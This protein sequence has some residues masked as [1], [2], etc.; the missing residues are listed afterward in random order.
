MATAPITLSLNTSNGFSPNSVPTLSLWLDAADATT[1]SFSSGINVSQWNDKS[2]SANNAT[3]STGVNQPTY[4]NN[5]VT[6]AGSQNL[7]SAVSAS[8]SSETFFAVVKPTSGE[9]TVLGSVATLDNSLSGTG[10]R[11]IL[12]IPS[13]S[14][15]KLNKQFTAEVAVGSFS[16]YNTRSLIGSLT[17]GTNAFV[18]NNGTQAGSG[19]FVS[20]T[21]GLFTIIGRNG[22]GTNQYFIG[23]MNEIIIYSA[24]LTTLQRQQVE[25]YL[26][27]KWGIQGNLPSNH[28]YKNLNIYAQPQLVRVSSTIPLSMT[29]NSSNVFNP[30]S[31]PGSQFWVDAADPTSIVL[32]G[33]SVTQW[34]DKSGNARNADSPGPNQ[35]TNAPTLAANFQNNLNAIS[36][37][38]SPG[39]CLNVPSFTSGPFT[40]FLVTKFNTTGN[41]GFALYFN[42]EGTV[43]T[44]TFRNFYGS[45]APTYQSIGVDNGGAAKR[46]VAASPGTN[47]TN[48]HI[49]A[50]TLPASAVGDFWL[51]GTLGDNTNAF[52]IPANTTCSAI[53]IGAY[54]Q[55]PTNA[56]LNG[57]VCEILWYNSALATIQRQQIEGYLAWKWGLQGS[58]P[59]S[60]P[61]KNI[62]I[63]VQP[64]LTS[65]SQQVI[66]LFPLSMTIQQ[67]SP[68]NITSL[69]LWL[70]AADASTLAFSSGINVSQWN[71]KSGNGYNFTTQ[72]GTPTYTSSAPLTRC[73]VFNAGGRTTDV[74]GTTTTF[75]APITVFVVST[76]RGSNLSDFSWILS[77]PGLTGSFTQIT[78]YQNNLA[79]E[80]NSIYANSSPAAT[81]V[82]PTTGLYTCVLNGASTTLT[83]NGA[84]PTGFLGNTPP[85]FNGVRLGAPWGD[86]PNSLYN[87][88]DYAEIIFYSSAL[89]PIQYQQVEGYLAWKWG[90]QA[91]LPERHLFKRYPPPPS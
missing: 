27:W 10:G 44:P 71:D 49:L 40:I 64:Q 24:A 46:Y 38:T 14:Q 63:Y 70:D 82:N 81:F 88:A 80:A 45:V 67:F 17:D 73:V 31:I 29:L 33:S 52:T 48:F 65:F 76:Q 85:G 83:R 43:N 39:S 26:A 79:I 3:Q 9:S 69:V 15:L 74:M 22:N 91:N 2:G 36:F 77:T 84:F 58:L 1:F 21:S 19:S 78:Y 35:T 53:T 89:S 68:K 87:I 61:Y 28:P 86:L 11:S 50:F 56:P 59:S 72:T 57:Y 13:P 12:L 5:T 66:P 4:A 20:Y 6:F 62:N 55:T 25:G 34:K 60:Q 32:S 75:N 51:D 37:T 47:D 7:L 41:T 16:A 54:N 8:L 30:L 23:E 18:Y 90:L 42:A